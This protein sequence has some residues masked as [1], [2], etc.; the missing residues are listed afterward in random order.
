MKTCCRESGSEQTPPRHQYLL[1]SFQSL[2]LKSSQEKN[3]LRG[4][5]RLRSNNNSQELPQ[6]DV[7]MP[8]SQNHE[9]GLFRTS[10]TYMNP[11]LSRHRK[12]RSVANSFEGMDMTGE[13]SKSERWSEKFV[14]SLQKSESDFPTSL[15]KKKQTEENGLVGG[16]S[17]GGGGFSP[18]AGK[19]LA[20]RSKQVIVGGSGQNVMSLGDSVVVGDGVGSSRGVRKSTSTPSLQD[21]EVGSSI[22]WPTSSKRSLKPDL[23]AASSAGMA[24]PILPMSGWRSKKA[25]D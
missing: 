14:R 8:S 3:S 17:G 15:E 6:S 18:I 20:Q 21:E 1:D 7:E 24:R 19:G 22:R 9:D 13:E 2:R 12:S 23:Q 25:V 4:Y 10:P 16:G 5:D 11:P